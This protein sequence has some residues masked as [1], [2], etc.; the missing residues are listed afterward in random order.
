MKTIQEFHQA[1]RQIMDENG[2]GEGVFVSV[3]M[4]SYPHYSNQ[5]SVIEYQLS[6]WI[7]DI[8][9]IIGHKNPESAIEELRLEIAKRKLDKSQVQNDISI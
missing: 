5:E 6:A 3:H 1:A 2:L 8:I 7:P 4:K 9:S